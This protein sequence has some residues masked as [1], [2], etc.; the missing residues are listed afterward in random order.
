M[1]GELGEQP[2]VYIRRSTKEQSDE[3]QVEDVTDWLNR[4]DL[5]I[6]DVEMYT[7]QGSG[8]SNDREDF[9]RLIGDIESGLITDVVVWEIS[10]IARNGTLAQKFFDTCEDAGVTVHIT[11]DAVRRVEPDGHGRLVADI[12]AS[13]AAEERRRLIERTK[14]GIETARKQGKWVGQVPAGFTTVDGYLKPNLN[15]DYDADETGFFDMY[16]AIEQ[17]EN[18]ESYRGTAKSTPNVTRQTLM[19]I[20][21]DEE[22]RAWYF[23]ESPENEHVDDALDEVRPLPEPDIAESA[24]E[25]LAERVEQLEKQI[26]GVGD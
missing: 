10:R 4:H 15:P 21:K 23:D 2:A 3:H 8:A 25:E 26:D 12:V 6:G 9:S 7:D 18:G 14:S 20:H 11:N 22:R 24:K 17:I 16:D 1:T 13:V 5:R 19:R